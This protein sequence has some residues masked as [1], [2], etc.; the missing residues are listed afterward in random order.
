ME[1]CS[2]AQAGVKW[3]DLGSLQPLPSGFTPFSCLSLLSSWD[4]RC[5]PPYMANFC[6][7]SR[8]GFSPCWPCWCWTPDLNW[9]ALLRLPECWDYMCEPPCPVSVFSCAP[10]LD[11]PGSFLL[12]SMP[13]TPILVPLWS[14][15]KDVLLQKQVGICWILVQCTSGWCAKVLYMYFPI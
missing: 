6:I 3:P 12:L 14:R 7:F 5:A 8:D 1:S 13:S 11:L 10:P 4:H 9:S 2:V 15:K